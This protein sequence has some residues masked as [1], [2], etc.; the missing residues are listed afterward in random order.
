MLNEHEKKPVKFIPQKENYNSIPTICA[1]SVV[2]ENL[3]TTR[4]S[5][6]DKKP[7]IKTKK[8]KE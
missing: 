8:T 1:H 7:N 3:P 4:I 2:N 5:P 6:T